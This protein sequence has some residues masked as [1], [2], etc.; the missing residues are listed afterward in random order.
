LREH[1]R[2]RENLMTKNGVRPVVKFG[3]LRLEIVPKVEK[4]IKGS[5]DGKH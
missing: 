1:E 4:F 2:E 5:G 3:K